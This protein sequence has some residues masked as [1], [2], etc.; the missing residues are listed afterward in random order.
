MFAA[1]DYAKQH[2]QDV[3]MSWGGREF[4]A[5]ATADATFV[6]PGVSF[7][8]AAGDSGART[9]YP[10]VSPNVVSIGGTQLD[11]DSL[12]HFS[13]ETAWSLTGSNHIAGGGGS[14]KF[15]PPTPAQLR[16]MQQSSALGCATRATPD[17]SLDASLASGLSVVF[18]P[19]RTITNRWIIVGG[20]SAAAPMAAGRAATTGLVVNAEAVYG[21]TMTFRDITIGFN[22]TP[23][24]V[25]YDECTGRGSWVGGT[26]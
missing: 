15:E 24:V 7:F 9:E 10:S 22:G 19:Q 17:F 11:F 12:G 8:A 6:A 1:V 3:S 4:G 5:E 20:T 23:C 2:A 21:N 14:A 26:P 18:T 16:F 25:G 13:L